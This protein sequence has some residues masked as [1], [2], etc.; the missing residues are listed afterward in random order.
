MK[1][2][3]IKTALILTLDEWVR[4]RF[5]PRQIV[6]YR[7]QVL[8]GSHLS[9]GSRRE[10][11][12]HVLYN[13]EV[14]NRHPSK[15][16]TVNCPLLRDVMGSTKGLYYLGVALDDQH[17]ETLCA[18]CIISTRSVLRGRR[19]V[20]RKKKDLRYPSNIVPLPI[21][22]PCEKSSLPIPCCA[23]SLRKAAPRSPV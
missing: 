18:I 22:R 14:Y 6:G 4:S 20:Y 15:S 9:N 11:H 3:M 16:L 12:R 21:P 2:I 8:P 5:K 17:P 1:T 19:F 7:C 10:R 23:R 13:G